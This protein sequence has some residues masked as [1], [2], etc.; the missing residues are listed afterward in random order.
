MSTNLGLDFTQIES[1]RDEGA[2]LFMH[3]PGEDTPQTAFISLDEY[4]VIQAGYN[5]AIGNAVPSDVWHRRTLRY[6][7]TP[8]I[9]G[10]RLA[11]LVSDEYIVGLLIRIHYG[12]DVKWN[13][14]NFVGILSDDA[15][16]ASSNLESALLHIEDD[17]DVKY[18]KNC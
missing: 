17:I 14:H 8:F 7:I 15:A 5:S 11:D 9:S 10:T 3:Y 16:E 12:H 18:S 1:L 2:P 6:R 13:G 4:G